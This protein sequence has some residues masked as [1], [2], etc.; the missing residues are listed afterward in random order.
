M[1]LCSHARSDAGTESN[2]ESEF[3]TCELFRFNLESASNYA[4][5]LPRA[6]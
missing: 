1:S 3:S 4:K 5:D 6:E 2:I